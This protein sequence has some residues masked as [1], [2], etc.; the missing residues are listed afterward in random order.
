MLFRSGIPDLLRQIIEFVESWEPFGGLC[1]ASVSAI[2]NAR[3]PFASECIEKYEE[4]AL[5][6]LNAAVENR[7]EISDV[8]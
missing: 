8:G 6:R 1:S 5:N 4:L 7:G 2:Q 3:F